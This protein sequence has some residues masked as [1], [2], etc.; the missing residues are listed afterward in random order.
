MVLKRDFSIKKS[1]D[2]G[3]WYHCILLLNL[4]FCITFLTKH[5][6][7][8]LGIRMSVISYPR[9][10]E[11]RWKAGIIATFLFVNSLVKVF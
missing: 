11:P 4:Q 10:W 2:V 8:V 3:C 6:N 1:G 9:A 7:C 5:P